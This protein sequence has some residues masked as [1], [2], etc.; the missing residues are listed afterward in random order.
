MTAGLFCVLLVAAVAVGVAIAGGTGGVTIERSETA[1]TAAADEGA[2]KREEVKAQIVVH[3]DGAV[4]APGVFTLVE[5]ARVNDAVLAAG[6]MTEGADT[7]TINLAAPLEDGAKVHVPTT[8]ELGS[9][10]STATS[11]SS[12]TSSSTAASN[13]L[14]NINT[15]TSADLQTLSGVGEATAQAIIDDRDANGPF[16]SPEDLMRVS[17][18]GEKKFAKIKGHI[19]V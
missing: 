14:V 16:S 1:E 17:G 4:A 8:E 10:P 6:G 11:D 5:G 2:A 12:G 9:A 18:I 15:A 13:G 3:V 7:S 19:C